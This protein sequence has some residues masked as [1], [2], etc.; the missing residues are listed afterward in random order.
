M[1]MKEKLKSPPE[2]IFCNSYFIL[3]EKAIKTNLNISSNFPRIEIILEFMRWNI[4][5]LGIAN[6]ILPAVFPF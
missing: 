1:Y 4:S 5:R 3:I 2:N 6:K